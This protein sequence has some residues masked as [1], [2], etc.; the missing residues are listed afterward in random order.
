MKKIILG[1]CLLLSTTS[2][3][4]QSHSGLDIGYLS[5]YPDG[6]T[7]TGFY[8]GLYYNAQLSSDFSV[9]PAVNYARAGHADLLY[10]PVMMKFYWPDTDFNI[11]AGPQATYILDNFADAEDRL[12]MDLN[13]GVGY[14]ILYNV[15]I[16]ARYGFKVIDSADSYPASDFN[17]FTIGIGIG[18]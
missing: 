16:N 18:L 11:Q 15:F 7:S 14:A 5:A 12:G 9:Q 6:K 1:F 3:F 4:A 17:T 8:A 10:L 2:L 13:V